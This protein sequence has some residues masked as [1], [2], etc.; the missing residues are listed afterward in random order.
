MTTYYSQHG[1]DAI[2]DKIFKHKKHGFFVEVGCIDGKRFS[3]TLVF[4]ERGWHGICVE[5]HSSYIELLKKNRP[6]SIVC[7]CAAAEKNENNAVFYANARGSL[8]TLDNSKEAY[9]QKEY[10]SYFTGFDEQPVNKRRL[11]T[12]FQEYKVSDIDILS[13]DIEGY[14][15]EALQGIDFTIYKPRVLVIESDSP[16]HEHKLD[17]ILLNFEYSKSFRIA[18]NVFY[19]V[20]KKMASLVIGKPYKVALL[21]TQHPLD[22]TGDINKEVE[23]YL[24]KEKSNFLKCIAALCRFLFGHRF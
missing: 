2:L 3:N 19:F 21:H 22:K 17:T 7:H 20:D 6:N 11:D 14:E 9:F 16:E 1:E 5:A 24:K 15:V 23:F 18:K 8:S 13:I 12:L 10:G 4:E